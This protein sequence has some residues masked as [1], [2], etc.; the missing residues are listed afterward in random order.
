MVGFDFGAL[1]LSARELFSAPAQKSEGKEQTI[2]VRHEDRL[3][4]GALKFFGQLVSP[5]TLAR[6][7]SLVV[8]A[9]K[10]LVR[11]YPDEK[12]PA[13]P[14]HTRDLGERF[15]IV[16]DVEMV[17]HVEGCH[18]MEALL[19][20]RHAL[21]GCLDERSRSACVGEPKRFGGTIE[22][23][24]GSE[25]AQWLEHASSAATG[26]EDRELGGVGDKALDEC[27]GNA[28]HTAE[29]P[30][31]VFELVEFSIL[32]VLH[33]SEFITGVVCA[34]FLKRERWS[35]T[36]WSPSNKRRP[37]VE[38]EVLVRGASR[39]VAAKIQTLIAITLVD[40]FSNLG[41]N[42]SSL[43]GSSLSPSRI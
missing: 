12:S 32:I 20:E 21:D 37:T 28:L 42:V 6:V 25:T 10:R 4:P 27:Q 40:A 36:N 1:A 7:D 26:I 11:R 41:G 22:G 43:A 29:P 38:V 30:H 24:Y 23:G 34:S 17:K 16:A 13:G 18:E 8:L 14:K 31:V 35:R 33:S 2:R 9:A 15:G 39:A 3:E 5:V 19:G